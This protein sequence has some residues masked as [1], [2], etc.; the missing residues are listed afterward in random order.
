MG[1]IELHRKPWACLLDSDL[2]LNNLIDE[3]FHKRLN[4]Y[5]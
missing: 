1:Y 4:E 3:V 2:R 5:S